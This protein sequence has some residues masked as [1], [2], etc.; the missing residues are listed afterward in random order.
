M[1]KRLTPVVVIA[2][3]SVAAAGAAAAD[4][5]SISFPTPVVFTFNAHFA[6]KKLPGNERVGGSLR[7]DDKIGMTDGSHPP[8][9]QEFVLQIDRSTVLDT[10]GLPVCHP[11]RPQEQE[12]TAGAE[13]DCRP[14]TVGEGKLEI[15]VAFPEA[16][17]FRVTSKML[18]FNGGTSGGKTKIYIPADLPSPIAATMVIQV[19]VREAPKGRYGL[20]A[21]AKVP[22]IAGGAA[23][24][25][26]FSLK[27][28]REFAYQGMPH[29]FL[30]LKCADGQILA[31]DT[32]AFS[33]GTKIIGTAVQPCTP[34]G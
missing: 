9:L 22:K 3:L 25:T 6:P 29:N 12:D 2:S 17:P 30:S 20:E 24:I 15:D 21:V 28:G 16:P 26:S 10:R 27:L 33:D 31:K 23:S 14:S 32:A 11:L 4:A 7:I 19:E 34:K 1:A 18:A 13:L 5:V 8:A